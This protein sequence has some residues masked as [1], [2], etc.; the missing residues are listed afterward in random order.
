MVQMAGA[1]HVNAGTCYG[2]VMHA[3]R[4]STAISAATNALLMQ[5]AHM[6][7]H[8]HA[9]LLL[10][11]GMHLCQKKVS[12][13]LPALTVIQPPAAFKQACATAASNWQ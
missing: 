11:Y 2:P 13:Q 6:Y 12:G 7:T 4:L 10:L 5:P 9:A 1:E 8:T 3:L